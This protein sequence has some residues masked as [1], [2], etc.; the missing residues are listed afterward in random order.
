[1][2]MAKWVAE[3][4]D[5]RNLPCRDPK[6]NVAAGSALLPTASADPGVA[7]PSQATQDA[8]SD[9]KEK[10][11]DDRELTFPFERRNAYVNVAAGSAP[12]PTASADASDAG[13]RP[14]NILREDN[15]RAL[16]RQ[17]YSPSSEPKSSDAAWLDAL[18]SSGLCSSSMNNSNEGDDAKGSESND[19]GS[20]R[21]EVLRMRVRQDVSFEM[22]GRWCAARLAARAEHQSAEAW[23]VQMLN[24]ASRCGNC[25]ARIRAGRVC[26]KCR[27][28]VC[29]E[30]GPDP[31]SF[32]HDERGMEILCVDCIAKERCRQ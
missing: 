27:R 3:L 16:V 32:P 12:L 30:C 6:V 18:A 24:G 29:N 13:L 28:G 11:G 8:T 26:G 9:W 25:R 20:L 7:G 23:G 17:E 2:A 14:K 19:E 21:E 31:E 10:L 1:M 4:G 15:F 5:A 22:S